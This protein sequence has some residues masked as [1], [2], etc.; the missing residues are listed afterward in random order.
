MN[1]IYV[2]INNQIFNIIN[3]QYFYY[4]ILKKLSDL[5]NLRFVIICL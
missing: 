5:L 3:K 4:Q 2:L 1:N